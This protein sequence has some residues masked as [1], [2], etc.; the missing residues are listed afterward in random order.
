[1]QIFIRPVILAI[2]LKIRLD[3]TLRQYREMES[4]KQFGKAINELDAI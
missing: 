1:M 3:Y 2:T 4:G